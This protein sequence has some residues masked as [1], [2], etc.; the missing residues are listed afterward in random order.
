MQWIRVVLVTVAT[1]R[2]TRLVTQDWI[3]HWWVVKP[4]RNWALERA[5]YIGRSLG[6]G[7]THDSDEVWAGIDVHNDPSK[8]VRLVSGLDCPF[9]VGFWIGGA[10]LLIDRILQGSWAKAPGHG[11]IGGN[12]LS[13]QIPG[14]GPLWRFAMAALALNYAVGHVSKR[15]D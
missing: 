3:G 12:S 5:G 15:I 6:G 1:M 2:L 7:Y 10:V 13:R 8:E 4:A 14:L 9:C 11:V